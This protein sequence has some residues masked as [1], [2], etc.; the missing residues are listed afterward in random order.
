MLL[1]VWQA[2][3]QKPTLTHLTVRLSS[4]HQRPV[5]IIP[6]IPSLR[7]L[8]VY[9]I[10]PLCYSDDISPLLFGA[11]GLD[12]LTLIW[13]HRM[14]KAHVPNVSLYGFLARY[15]ARGEKLSLK[16]L[17]IKNLCV[18]DPQE[19]RQVF[20]RA[21][22]E[23][24]TF[25]N[26]FAGPGDDPETTFF[27]GNLRW[28]DFQPPPNLK[29]LRTDAASPFRLE[30]LSSTRGL[31]RLYFVGSQT[32][33]TKSSST[34][35]SH[36]ELEQLPQSPAS[37]TRSRPGMSA[38][39]DLKDA[40]LEVITRNH[41]NTLRHLL[42]MP[43]WRLSSE[44]IAII[45]R[46]CPNLEQLGIGLEFGNFINLRLLAPF[47]GNLAALRLLD[48][49]DNP[50]FS[51]KMKELDEI[52]V[53]EEK[54]G[55]DH[56]HPERHMKWMELGE[57]LFEIGEFKPRI[58]DKDTGKVVYQRPVWKRPSGSANHV[59]IFALDSLEV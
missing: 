7:S 10:D 19:I 38:T 23:E 1:T 12:E 49:P 45:V 6:P 24:I 35:V 11:K 18:H 44:D 2:L 53:H 13:N 32:A 50:A 37:S 33:L 48:N 52:G 42:L 14:R 20:I 5:S 4:Q 41:G 46:Q 47:L 28:Q 54:I 56:C 58:P 59:E 3:V 25:L 16:S 9:D 27:A 34:G 26:S 30:M 36:A 29:M 15:L 40:Y 55:G 39:A 8:K 57:L 17:V 43:Q 31:E 22:I 51:M 21:D